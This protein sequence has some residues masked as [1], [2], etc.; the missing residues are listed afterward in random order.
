MPTSH[1]RDAVLNAAGGD[2]WTNSATE[3][4]TPA[5]RVKITI[6]VSESAPDS[7]WEA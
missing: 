5:D 6:T 2:H 1:Q 4:D 7:F 3:A